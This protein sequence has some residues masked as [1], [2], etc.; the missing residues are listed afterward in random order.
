MAGFNLTAQINLR[1]PANVKKVV[2]GIQKQ[3][4]GINA[5]VNLNLNKNTVKVLADA[6]KKL[7]AINSSLGKVSANASKATSAMAQ[8]ANTLN[9]IGTGNVSVKIQNASKATRQLGNNAKISFKNIKIARSEIEEFGRQSALAVRRFTAF[10]SVTS[11]IYGVNNAI[12]QALSDFIKFDR[13]LV[14]VSQVSGQ[15]VSS[16]QGLQSTIGQLSSSFG[17]SSSSLAEISGYLTQAGLSIRQVQQALKALALTDVAPTFDNLNNTVEGSIALMR[18]FS[19]STSDLESSL[20]SIN[21]VAA[22]FAVESSDII[23]A[24]QRA[25]G[26]FAAASKGVSE[27]TDALNEFIAIFTSVRATTREGA[28]TIA[29]GLRTIFTRLQR[30]STIDAL[31]EFGVN[32]QDAEGKFVGAYKAVQLLSEGLGGLDPRDIRFSK[33]VEELGGFRQIGK[34]IPLIAKFATAQDAL[35]VAQQGQGS[36][37]ESAARSQQALAVQIAKVRE[38]FLQLVR[39]ISGTDTFKGLVSG[40]LQFASV[41][42]KVADSIKGILPILAALAA[43]RGASAITQFARGFSGGIR[44][45]QGFAKGGTVPGSGNTDSVPAMLT[46]GEFVLRKS[47]V[48]SIGTERLHRMNKYASGDK[49]KDII[50]T[51][52]VSKQLSNSVSKNK[53]EPFRKG[54]ATNPDDRFFADIAYESIS[55]K[56]IENYI[57]TIKKK[58][59]RQDFRARI[60]S[61]TA[62]I[63]GEAFEQYLKNSK[64]TNLPRTDNLSKTYPVDFTKPGI[65][66]E[67]KNV[68][69]TIPDNVFIDKLYRARVL[70][71]TYRSRKDQKGEYPSSENG[72]SIDLGKLKVFYS[73]FATGGS[74]QDTVPA[75]LTP[76]EFV[77]NK[78]SASRIGYGN[79]RKMN[80]RPQGFNKGGI[81]GFATGGTPRKAVGQ[82]GAIDISGSISSLKALEDTLVQMKLPATDLTKVLTSK[83]QVDAKLYQ[84]ALRQIRANLKQARASAQSSTEIE[85]VTALENQLAKARRSYASKRRGRAGGRAG[86]AVEKLTGEAGFYAATALAGAAAAAESF[87]TATGSAVSGGLTAMAQGLAVVQTV[88][89]TLPALFGALSAVLPLSTAGLAGLTA[90]LAPFLPIGIAIAAVLGG[91]YVGFSALAAYQKKELE[92]RKKAAQSDLDTA[93]TS[94]EKALQALARS[95]TDVNFDS[96]INS[97]KNLA[98]AANSL[99]NI[100]I[101][102]LQANLQSGGRETGVGY[103]NWRDVVRSQ[104]FG[105]FSLFVDSAEQASRQN[106]D[107][108]AEASRSIAETAANA[109]TQAATVA[110]ARFAKGFSLQDLSA[111]SQKR[112]AG[113][114]LTADEKRNADIYD[115]LLQR[116]LQADQEYID[117]QLAAAS[118]GRT[119][120]AAEEQQHRSR[121]QA[122]MMAADS[123]INLASKAEIAARAQEQLAKLTAE[124]AN[125]FERLNDAVS[126][127]INRLEYESSARQRSLD[128]M[129]AAG[130]GGAGPLQIESRIANVVDNPTAYTD[131]DRRNTRINLRE[132]LTP[133]LGAEQAAEVSALATFDPNTLTQA[134]NDATAGAAIGTPPSE[135]GDAI[136]DNLATEL[137]KL[138]AAGVSDGV[139][140]NL[141]AQARETSKVIATRLQGVEDP[142]ER[143]RIIAEETKKLRDSLA[144]AREGAV[145]VATAFENFR[146]GALNEFGEG[147]AKISDLQKQALEFEQKAINTRR[148]AS[149]SFNQALTGFG[150]SIATL[151]ARQ[152][153]DTARL[154]GGPTSPEDIANNFR[155]LSTEAD[156]LRERIQAA[157]DA[158]DLEEV[159]NLQ[160]ELYGVNAQLNNNRTALERLAESANAAADAALN[161]VNERKRFQDANRQFAETLL[162]SG[163]DELKAMDEALVRANQRLN[164]F[165]PQAGA[166]QRKKFFE[167]LKQTGS[168]QQASQ[169]V[170]A[171]TRRQDLQ[172]L[173]QTRDVRIGRMQDDLVRQG[174]SEDEA[175]RMATERADQEEARILAQM[176]GEA[177]LGALGRSIVGQAAATTADRMND[178]VMR[179]LQAQ[180]QQA[181]EVQATANEQL[182]NLTRELADGALVQTMLNLQTNI[183]D[184]N[185]TIRVATGQSGANNKPPDPRDPRRQPIVPV[186]QS[187]G[188]LIYAADG[189]YI[190]FE[191]KGTDTVPA[192]LTPGEFVVNRSATQKNMGLLQAING[193]KVNTYSKGGKV[194][195]LAGGGFS[196]RDTN[197]DGVLTVGVEDTSGLND[198]NS[199]GVI[200]LAEFMGNQSLNDPTMRDGVID[201]IMKTAANSG[202]NIGSGS[203]F[204]LNLPAAN[205]GS[206]IGGFLGNIL[207]GGLKGGILGAAAGAGLGALAPMKKFEFQRFA[208]VGELLPGGRKFGRA[209]EARKVQRLE[210]RRKREKFLQDREAAIFAE[211]NRRRQAAGLPP[212]ENPEEQ[213]INFRA[214]ARARREGIG[215]REAKA[216]E[217]QLQNRIVADPD[218][219]IDPNT[220]MVAQV[221]F[222]DLPPRQQKAVE[223]RERQAEKARVARE[224]QRAI[225]KAIAAEKAREQAEIDAAAQQRQK[226]QDEKA[227]KARQKQIEDSGQG[228]YKDIY[229]QEKDNEGNITYRP[230]TEREYRVKKQDPN[231]PADSQNLYD[232]EGNRIKNDENGQRALNVALA[233]KIE[234]REYEERYGDPANRRDRYNRESIDS[235][236]I[237]GADGNRITDPD[238]L[239]SIFINH[240]A[241]GQDLEVKRIPAYDKYGKP[242]DITEDYDYGRYRQAQRDKIDQ[243]QRER[244]SKSSEYE[245]YIDESYLD[246][247]IAKAESDADGRWSLSWQHARRLREQ[248]EQLQTDKPLLESFFGGE[249]L[250]EEFSD[251]M[252][253]PA[254]RGIVENELARRINEQNLGS[255]TDITDQFGRSTEE[256][257]NEYLNNQDLSN[258]DLGKTIRNYQRAE[259]IRQSDLTKK[260]EEYKD[261]R[262]QA[263]ES[264]EWSFT[265]EQKARYEALQGLYRKGGELSELGMETYEVDRRIIDSD[266]NEIAGSI[267]DESRSGNPVVDAILGKGKE[268]DQQVQ[269]RNQELRTAK[270]RA[271]D[272]RR[273]REL[274]DKQEREEQA[275]AYARSLTGRAES[276]FYTTGL[277]LVSGVQSTIDSAVG[278]RDDITQGDTY[279]TDLARL[280][281]LRRRRERDSGLSSKELEE[282][283]RLNSKLNRDITDLPGVESGLQ[284]RYVDSRYGSVR[285]AGYLGDQFYNAGAN[286][287]EAGRRGIGALTQSDQKFIKYTDPVTGERVRKKNEWYVDEAFQRSIYENATKPADILKPDE[288]QERQDKFNKD[289]IA[290]QSRIGDYAGYG[291]YG[292]GYVADAF[293]TTGAGQ[294]AMPSELQTA[295]PKF[296]DDMRLYVLGQ[297]ESL[298]QTGRLASSEDVLA[299]GKSLENEMNAAEQGNYGIGPSGA[300][301]AT[302]ALT[303]ALLPGVP[304]AIK[305][306]AALPAQATR[307]MK[308]VITEAL[309]GL[310]DFKRVPRA[311]VPDGPDIELNS[312]REILSLDAKKLLSGTATPSDV[313][314]RG[315]FPT[316]RAVQEAATGPT[317][318]IPGLGG[319]RPTTRIPLPGSKPATTAGSELSDE[320]LAFIDDIV[321]ERAARGAAAQA[322][323]AVPTKAPASTT[324]SVG[325][326]PVPDAV[327]ANTLRGEMRVGKELPDASMTPTGPDIDVTDP[328][329]RTMQYTDESLRQ[330]L[331]KRSGISPEQMSSLPEDRVRDIASRS[332]DV[333]RQG[334]TRDEFIKTQTRQAVATREITNTQ[335]P[336]AAALWSEVLDPEKLRQGGMVYANN[337]A[338]IPFRSRGTDTVPAMLT[339]GEFVV[340]REATSKYLPVLRAINSGYNSHN[341]MV[342]HLA[343]GGMVRGPQYLQEGGITRQGS[344]NGVSTSSQIQGIEE[345]RAVVNELNQAVS[346]GTENMNNVATQVT[347]ATNQ[348]ASTAQSINS[349]ALNIPDSVNVAQNVRVDGIPDTLNDFSNNLLNSSVS[350][351]RRQNQAVDTER[352][353]RNEGA[354]GLPPPSSPIS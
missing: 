297:L 36:L 112:A 295:D 218:G 332:L 94:T 293:V 205:A 111:A 11:V 301:D 324:T 85:K 310:K 52:K 252:K 178:P 351:S 23:S 210:A 329:L 121:V 140:N 139:I 282:L 283:Q 291:A 115:Q 187:R 227:R 240:A 35:K 278:T 60:F 156:G 340:N 333:T 250:T 161:E 50:K 261:L 274:L 213:K 265:P 222:G 22:K 244:R 107:R 302:M 281:D 13:Q 84:S 164:G 104:F 294:F 145:D 86:A 306:T 1:G 260:I 4:N 20:S 59:D 241:I 180:Y 9:S 334:G 25:G 73:K 78:E 101:E 128:S 292:L 108:I 154:T 288:I 166:S 234:D 106:R 114:A 186:Q 98:S 243:E 135:L 336:D 122:S 331:L 272:E 348:F 149:D 311:P 148:S 268:R 337:G 235:V 87:G 256:V 151:R 350:E 119:L 199:D 150:P 230:L 167:L 137:D 120:T 90:T 352:N 165:I 147:L 126:Q 152:D 179:G 32:L 113:G 109:Y 224:E 217:E 190:N 270:Q 67:A 228:T 257:F 93:S 328:Y 216:A 30:E 75:M 255:Q 136:S 223:R 46:P 76:G 201:S 79:L 129:I 3:L 117:A 277:T 231:G 191:P 236:D 15:A 327:N 181:T 39:D 18:Q 296:R 134:V 175:R 37:A 287:T 353:T 57:R 242:I 96:A 172:F 347:S 92:I 27:G 58:K 219:A 170:A 143:Q 19:I 266:N 14:R 177:G 5:N 182:A 349:A 262:K 298:Q 183:E 248:K 343:R 53:E 312:I 65:Y 43:A 99:N 55:R 251:R 225:E 253:D 10:A 100:K 315:M 49:V 97:I 185:R 263:I 342:N 339:P 206:A 220:G 314:P 341:E 204:G 38:Q 118:Q 346:S 246:R 123:D 189:Q 61:S 42:I 132:N 323:D 318:A 197:K 153:A 12:N 198:T 142:R 259:N 229:V 285:F 275:D 69:D 71:N 233:S 158:G 254:F 319:V 184:L 326:K 269:Q 146:T 317:R 192:M 155:R 212:L 54:V 308:K 237:Y 45:A 209:A 290:F 41:L 345:L 214:K 40:G 232:N 6:D 300:A 28:E 26:V 163:P 221:R 200:T 299:R 330:S 33:I 157:N 238:T 305:N 258:S 286:I 168:V 68:K 211:R 103:G 44:R 72:Q 249:P 313:N 63:K 194:R 304:G 82:S 273:Y 208:G 16:L 188:G 130:T 239:S 21:A 279:Q 144:E 335:G 81:V 95:A 124:L 193:G 162:T 110:Q 88:T 276:A 77:F 133:A 215:L 70:D 62:A 316:V 7:R 138:R 196:D 173:R 80:T 202:S 289:L 271:D 171:D 51:P 17:V 159:A 74:A 116:R 125:N 338:L 105:I 31:K 303:E 24:V 320:A 307:G 131:E 354:D 284:K 176:G 245:K 203:Q 34:V 2:A 127:S 8:F 89:A 247:E 321:S 66:A 344:N 280:Q 264:G 207:G 48:K 325:R 169:G 160:Q 174:V 91:L 47:A 195:Y 141:Q 226:Q 102:E 56:Q 64:K 309:P 83:G 29:T 267:A 322:A